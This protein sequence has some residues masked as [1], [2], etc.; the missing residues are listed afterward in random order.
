M[1]FLFIQQYI[2]KNYFKQS[3]HPHSIRCQMVEKDENIT[4]ILQMIRVVTFEPE[5]YGSIVMVT[6][7][8]MIVRKPFQE[9]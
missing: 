2:P 9:G 7:L 5:S 1:L 8:R 3:L 4:I 6:L